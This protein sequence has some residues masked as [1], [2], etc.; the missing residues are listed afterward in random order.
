[1]A[2]TRWPGLYMVKYAFDIDHEVA[3]PLLRLHG[4]PLPGAVINIGATGD[5]LEEDISQWDRV[6]GTIAGPPCPPYSRI[7]ARRGKY[8]RAAVHARATDILVDQGWKHSFF[9]IVEQ[10]PGMMARPSSA[11]G[12]G[13]RSDWE[14]W[15]DELTQR[16]PMWR[17]CSMDVEQQFMVA[18]EPATDLHRGFA[19]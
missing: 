1:M 7:G 8:P 3:V 5:I 17:F 15:S 16:A 14:E 19:R 9:F 6:D 11:S 12:D 10:V 18:T 2:E 4:P 13:S